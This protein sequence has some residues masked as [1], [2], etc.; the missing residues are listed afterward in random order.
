MPATARPP[1]DDEVRGALRGV[2]DPE[3]GSDIVGLGRVRSA[4]IGA[5]GG[6]TVTLA[7]TTAGCPLR[8]QLQRDVRARVGSLP[9]VTGVH[10][11]WTE[12]T[13]AERTVA[14]ERARFNVSQR[15]EQTSV[16]PTTRVLAVASGK[17][18]VG[19]SSVTVNLAAA[20]AA[21]GLKVGVLDADIW[22]FAG[23]RM[24][25]VDGR[26]GGKE[27][28]GRKVML[29]NERTIDKGLVRVV[30]MGFLVDDE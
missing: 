10:L 18:G 7:L 13:D 24:L 9:G 4:S 28:D 22:G 14:M 12:M 3:L 25:G 6:V 26:L 15:E 19:K 21:Q 11:D 17:G 2:I 20:L 29:P 30:S 27:I 23:P 1:T 5:D 8:A 16:A